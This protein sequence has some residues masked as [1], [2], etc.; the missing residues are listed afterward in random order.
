MDSNPQEQIEKEY[1]RGHHE[2]LKK[3]FTFYKTKKVPFYLPIILLIFL[4][5]QISIG[6]F[7]GTFELD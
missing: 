4:L 7:N 3:K 1:P 5:T 2:K 6:A